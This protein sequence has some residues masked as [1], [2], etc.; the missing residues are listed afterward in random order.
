VL[1]E[2]KVEKRSDV[3]A[4]FTPRRH[5]DVVEVHVEDPAVPELQKLFV[6]L[7]RMN[8]EPPSPP[9]IIRWPFR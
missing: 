1:V 5:V 8:R 3:G 2:P 4:G 7:R 6:L 9:G